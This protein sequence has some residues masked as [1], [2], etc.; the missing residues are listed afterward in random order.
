MSLMILYLGKRGGGAL[1]TRQIATEMSEINSN[2]RVYL[3]SLNEEVE[4]Y[5]NHLSID[6]FTIPFKSFSNLYKLIGFPFLLLNILIILKRKNIKNILFPMLSP[7]DYSLSR[8]FQLFGIKV[9]RIIHDFEPHPG[10]K[11]PDRRLIRRAAKQADVAICLSKFVGDNFRAIGISNI[12]SNFPQYVPL[13]KVSIE[14]VSRQI[15]LIGRGNEYKNL[16]F[17]N[18]LS[19]YYDLKNLK[20]VVAGEL[21]SR[22]IYLP[23]GIQIEFHPGWLSLNELEYFIG[24]SEVMLLPYVSASQS[25]L[26]DIAVAFNTKI[27]ATPVGGLLEQ[28]INSENGTIADSPNDHDIAQALIK[29]LNSIK[30]QSK[31]TN[32]VSKPISEVLTSLL[33]DESTYAD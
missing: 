28:V 32:N 21:G 18:V 4:N 11:W 6:T 1:L 33:L 5:P 27:V 17:L 24:S 13:T 25:G 31:S 7:F 20:I 2:V 29:S 15:C 23:K 22:E 8:V 19:N 30:S 3:T 10:D 26:V 9:I 16:E 14:K 12:V